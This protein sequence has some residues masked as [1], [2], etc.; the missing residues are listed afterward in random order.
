MMCCV[1]ILDA[2]TRDFFARKGNT[3]ENETVE[4]SDVQLRQ[5]R[6]GYEPISSTLWRQREEFCARSIQAYWKQFAK[7]KVAARLK[8][9]ADAEL[10]ERTIANN[11]EVSDQQRPSTSIIID[12]A[13]DFQNIDV[14][15]TI[16]SRSSSLSSRVSDV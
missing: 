9:A 16:M 2:L 12:A 10:V 15:K 13:E 1:D 3:I 5:D 6:P 8:L 7:D 4:L 11:G 14:S